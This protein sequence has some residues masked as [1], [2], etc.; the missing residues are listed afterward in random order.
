MDLS[1]LGY[2]CAHFSERGLSLLHLAIWN[3]LLTRSHD[4][5]H[6]FRPIP[7]SVVCPDP[8]CPFIRTAINSI[9]CIWTNNTDLPR[10]TIAPKLIV[11]CV[12]ILT[13]LLTSFVLL[14]I[15]RGSHNTT[16]FKKP[17]PSFGTNLSSIKF[18][19][20]DPI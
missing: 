10:A 12:L 13:T 16:E 6:Q 19:D 11:L 4:R 14:C 18:I 1:V 17:S 8:R 20:E 3:T 5:T 2:D 9:Y 7:S 15:C